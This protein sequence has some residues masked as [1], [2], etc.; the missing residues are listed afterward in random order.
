MRNTLKTDFK[1]QVKSSAVTRW[2]E[3]QY[4]IVKYILD[5]TGLCWSSRVL[6]K[7]MQ[8]SCFKVLTGVNQK[9]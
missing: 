4:Q 6:G 1:A 5:P 2:P 8:E 3:V 7:S 9:L